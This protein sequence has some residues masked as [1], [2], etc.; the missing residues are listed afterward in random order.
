MA[1]HLM[2]TSI[3]DKWAP[4]RYQQK[5]CELEPIIPYY[6]LYP[7]TDYDSF[8]S[9]AGGASAPC[10]GFLRCTFVSRRN[11]VRPRR[12]AAAGLDRLDQALFRCHLALLCRRMET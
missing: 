9:W 11:G 6:C 3:S 12:L 2:P 8:P 7:I 4:E 10:A 1:P 5:I